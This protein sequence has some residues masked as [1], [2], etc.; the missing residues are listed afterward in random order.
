MDPLEEILEAAGIKQRPERTL[1]ERDG[2]RAVGE[3]P[4][5]SFTMLDRGELDLGLNGPAAQQIWSDDPYGILAPQF[6]EFTGPAGIF[7]AADPTTFTD[8]T[9][10]INDKPFRVK[11]FHITTNTDQETS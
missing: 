1:V 5:R 4:R 2:H 10:H 7:P 3:P 8:A 9:L 6:E 11:N